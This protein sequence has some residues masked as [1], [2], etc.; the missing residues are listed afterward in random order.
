[1]AI[2]SIGDT[3]AIVA[4]SNGLDEKMKPKI[5]ELVIILNE[6]GLKT[7]ISDKV[8]K[9]YSAFN[10]TGKERA[11]VLLKYYRH[12]EVKA[13]FDVSGGDLSNEI[14]QY[15]DFND[16]NKNYKPYFGYSDL[17]VVVNALYSKT[18]Q[19]NYLYQIRNLVDSNKIEQIKNF[20]DT[21][22]DDNRSILN[23]EY[24]WIQ[25]NFMS[26]I[27]VGGNIRCF[28]KL[29]GTEYMPDFKDKL[30]F[31]ESFSG[32]VPK[33]V[34]YLTQYKHMGIFKK[35]NGIILGSYTEM[36]RENYSPTIVDII[37]RI[38]DDSSMPIVK[39]NEIGHG[40]DSKCIIIGENLTLRL[41]CN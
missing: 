32:D 9:K 17:T 27:V 40:I 23:F 13:I 14:L 15:L 37:K 18:N 19:K 5:E 41:S 4:C 8:Y 11:D 20:K 7:I 30:L 28:L 12:N 26:G 31:L 35:V 10:G 24:E 39:T 38:V 6:I 21:F 29:A 25:G 2:L 36:E 3:V 22:I 1:M 34:S 16:I 33:M